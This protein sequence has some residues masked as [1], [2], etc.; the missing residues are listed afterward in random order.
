MEETFDA[1]KNVDE[2][3]FN[4]ASILSRL[5]TMGVKVVNRARDTWRTPTKRRTL[6]PAKITFAGGNA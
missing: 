2:L 6:I 3:V 4:R 1:A 5:K